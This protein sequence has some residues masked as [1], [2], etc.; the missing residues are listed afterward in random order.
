M[1]RLRALGVVNSGNKCFVNAVLQLLI[2]CPPFWNLFKDRGRLIGQ[3]ELGEGHWQETG[4]GATPLV[5]ATIKFLDE[6]IYKETL[7]VMQRPQQKAGKGKSMGDEEEK[8]EHDTVDSL[9]LTYVYDVMKEKRQL[10]SLLVRT[11]SLQLLIHAVLLCTGRPATGCSRVFRP[12]PR[13]AR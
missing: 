7:S 8:I 12:L 9:E 3:Q 11:L 6:F 10:N 1:R 5:D 4:R 2:H 13:G